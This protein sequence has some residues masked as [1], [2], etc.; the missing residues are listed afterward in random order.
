[1]ASPAKIIIDN[2]YVVRDNL[3]DGERFEEAN[4]MDILIEAANRAG[5]EV[6]TWDGVADAVRKHGPWLLARFLE[7]NLDPLL[8]MYV[9]GSV[10]Q[11]FAQFAAGEIKDV[12]VDVSMKRADI[13]RLYMEAAIPSSKL[14][15]RG[16]DMAIEWKG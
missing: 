13:V 15:L 3:V 1:M 16:V 4:T 9:F 6:Y 7:L 10:A 14:D 12:P 8:L 11:S 5:H 2:L